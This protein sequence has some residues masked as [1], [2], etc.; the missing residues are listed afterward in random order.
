MGAD[1]DQHRRRDPRDL[2]AGEGLAAAANAGGEGREVGVGLLGELAERPSDR[3]G[4]LVERLASS[5]KAI[6][7]G[8]PTP[9]TK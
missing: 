1:R 6:N 3:I 4:H 2:R 5:A 9:S 7:S 8:K